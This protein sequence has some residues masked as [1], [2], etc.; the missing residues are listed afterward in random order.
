MRRYLI[1]GGIILAAIFALCYKTNAQVIELACPAGTTSVQSLQS[2][3]VPTG[4][5]RQNYCID[6]AGN[7]F[8]N[9][10]GS[11]AITGFINLTGLGGAAVQSAL[12]SLVSGNAY[13]IPCG[14]YVGPT[15]IPSNVSLTALGPQENRQI[16]L[17]YGG[18]VTAQTCVTFTYTANLVLTGIQNTHCKG[19]A[20]DFGQGGFGVIFKD[21][22][23][24]NFWDH[25]AITNAGSTTQPA[26]QFNA[27]T[28]AG[29]SNVAHN[30]FIGQ[31]V[32]CRWSTSPFSCATAIQFLGSGAVNAGGFATDNT[33][34]NTQ[35]AGNI[36]VCVDEELNSDSNY[37][38]DTWCNEDLGAAP[39]NSAQLAI[40][41][42]TPASDQ[43]ANGGVVSYISWTGPAPSNNIR[44]GQTRGYDVS[45]VATAGT[46]VTSLGGTQLWAKLA[47]LA[48]GSVTPQLTTGGILSA[49]AFTTGACTGTVAGDMCA[50][51]NATTGY[52]GLGNDGAG[53]LK[54][55]GG[56]FFVNTNNA[57]MD[58]SVTT[59]TAAMTTAAIASLACGT[60]VSV[61]N[62]AVS[63]GIRL[64]PSFTVAPASPNEFLI[65]RSWP[66]AGNANFAWC[67]PTAASQT[68]VAE[69]ITWT[70]LFP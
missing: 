49:N 65:L 12:N 55:V 61:A 6:N 64:I 36:V 41:Q 18:T 26:L 35:V 30:V 38:Y 4:K 47:L 52:L 7:V 50:A 70:A 17:D 31:K 44:A 67:N 20:M 14:T 60:T 23:S 68:P 10:S 57:Q 34:I 66:T 42:N 25:C 5:I 59:G 22:S 24:G 48:L 11:I 37:L 19:I 56:N 3:D 1:R 29:T 27:S 9:L 21:G 54:R 51:E 32:D 45:L 43:D 53:F 69:T 62:A 16:L 28:G 58:Q 8:Q 39:A 15:S 13:V 40:N 33:M 63:T 2:I 46:P